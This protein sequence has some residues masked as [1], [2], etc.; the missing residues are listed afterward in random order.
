M[1]IDDINSAK[2]ELSIHCLIVI[3]VS[4]WIFKI[5]NVKLKFRWA[6]CST[7][8]LW[9]SERVQLHIRTWIY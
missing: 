3:S 4:F 9:Q 6:L 8:K 2:H 7:E 5:L 1:K